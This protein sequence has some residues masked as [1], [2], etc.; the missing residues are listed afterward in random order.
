METETEELA[1][2]NRA[3]FLFCVTIFLITNKF[4]IG[5][6]CLSKQTQTLAGN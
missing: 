4:D 1:K 2:G 6:K 5:H 3:V